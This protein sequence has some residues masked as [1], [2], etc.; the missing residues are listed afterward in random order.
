[1]KYEV[2]AGEA[3]TRTYSLSVDMIVFCVEPTIKTKKEKEECV[4]KPRHFTLFVLTIFHQAK[5]FR[6]EDVLLFV[7]LHISEEKRWVFLMWP[8][9]IEGIVRK[10]SVFT[11]Y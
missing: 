2:I 10:F 9:T 7:F 5:L 4:R 8:L 11:K 1:M 6:L 3:S